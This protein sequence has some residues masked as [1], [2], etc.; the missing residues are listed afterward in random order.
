MVKRNLIS[1]LIFSSQIASAGSKPD[2]TTRFQEQDQNYKYYVG[3]A[4]QFKSEADAFKTARQNA[5][6]DL[7]LENYGFET[8]I[9][10]E[11]TS[12]TQEGIV[13]NRVGE[14]SQS[15]QI[16]DFEQVDRYVEKQEDHSL[17]VW[18]L[19][20]YSQAA[21]KAEKLR[22]ASH[23]PSD[24]M[25]SVESGK[26]NLKN[27]TVLEVNSVPDGAEVIIDGERWGVTPLKINGSLSPE[28]HKIIIDHP[29][30]AVENEKI[31]LSVT[32]KRSLR[33]I[34]RRAYGYVIL[35]SNPDG[36][37]VGGKDHFK[38]ETPTRELKFLANE[39]F[40]LKFEHPKAETI[41]RSIRVGR[42]EHVTIE[43]NLPLK[44]A[45]FKW[46]SL[47]ANV[48]VYV[49]QIL[50]HHNDRTMPTRFA[51]GPGMSHR[52]CATKA[53]FEPICHEDHFDGG[54]VVVY[55]KAQFTR[56][57]HREFTIERDTSSAV[58]TISLISIFDFEPIPPIFNIF[59]GFG[60]ASLAKRNESGFSQLGM[61]VK[62]S[63]VGPI[64]YELGASFCMNGSGQSS[65]SSS[66]TSSSTQGG[67]AVYTM[68]AYDFYVGM[69]VF[70]KVSSHSR[71]NLTVEKGWVD[72]SFYPSTPG[73]QTLE[74]VQSRM[75]FGGGFV[76]VPAGNKQFGWDVK[77]LYNNYSDTSGLKG[78]SSAM[79]QFGLNH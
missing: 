8:K 1:L 20:R 63:L 7:V 40:E 18:V 27:E 39:A 17:D 57:Q 67:S 77:I 13:V 56:T 2:W 25:D 45:Y 74:Y 46:P 49:D 12:T 66:S 3:R 19:Y 47:N 58:P 72:S 65:N 76:V 33:K 78:Q 22:I 42:D 61:S 35:K 59:L 4:S 10:S 38:T 43:V 6:A 29:D 50:V 26:L 60:G 11:T 34:L 41:S 21:L 14:S 44:P 62:S 30:Y 48:T 37:I 15:I 24:P 53:E 55:E 64:G 68:N 9:D 31:N 5:I 51:V 73:Y 70:I 32:P 79:I 54:Q 71:A 75:G 36:A 52:I 69:P 28:E 16:K 23:T